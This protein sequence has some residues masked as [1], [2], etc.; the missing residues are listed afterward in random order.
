MDDQPALLVPDVAV[1]ETDRAAPAQH[2]ALGEHRAGTDRLHEA[3]LE[4]ERRDG[5][6]KAALGDR[7][8]GHGDVDHAGQEAALADAA[9]RMAEGRNDLEAAATDPARGVDGEERAVEQARRLDPV[10]V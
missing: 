10:V 7:G 9:P 8:V 3:D 1:E 4:L 2:A 6:G 5:A